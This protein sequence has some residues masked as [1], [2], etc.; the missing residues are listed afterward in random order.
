MLSFTPIG[1][2]NNGPRFSNG[3]LSISAACAVAFSSFE[4]RNACTSPS[5]FAIRSYASFVKSAIDK[6]PALISACN[7]LAERSNSVMRNP[8]MF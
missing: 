6:L 7:S 5:S 1:R 3:T 4:A 8:P 2:P